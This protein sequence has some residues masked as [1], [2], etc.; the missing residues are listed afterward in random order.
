MRK[1]KQSLFFAGMSI[2]LSMV[3]ALPPGQYLGARERDDLQG[4]KDDRG[5]GKGKGNLCDHPPDPKGKAKGLDD[6]CP[7]GGSSNGVARGDFNNDGFADLAIGV[8]GQV[9]AGRAEAG[10]VIV[11]YGSANRLT[12]TDPSVPASQFWSQDSLGVPDDSEAR[13]GFGSALAAGDFNGDGFSDLAIG[14][15]GDK[16]VRS[17]VGSIGQV[18]VIYGSRVGLTTDI[19]LG[20]PAS[21]R[22]A[23]TDLNIGP[24]Q[25]DFFAAEAEA[26]LPDG[27]SFGAALAWGDFDADGFSDLAVGSP[28]ERIQSLD[29]G[30][31][32][33]GAGAVG[34][35]FG[36]RTGLTVARSFVFTQNSPGVPGDA[37]GVD[38]FGFALAGGDFNGDGASDLAI[39][40]PLKRFRDIRAAGEVVVLFGGDDRFGLGAEGSLVF[41]EPLLA[42]QAPGGF[43]VP[44]TGTGFRFGFALAAGDFNGDGLDDLAMSAPNRTVGTQ[45]QAGAVWVKHG[46]LAPESTP[47]FW[48]Q[49][50]VFPGA[51]I[52]NERDGDGSPPEADDFFGSALAAG[53][54]NG[55]GRDDLAIG[56]PFED[57]L[58]QRTPTTFEQV[59]D[60]GAV[61]VIYGSADGLSI[62]GRRPQ[63]WT[64]QSINIE[65]DA[66]SGD[67]FGTSLTAWNFGGDDDVT[68]PTADLAIGVPFENVGAVRDAGAV[69][70]I[71]GS[72]RFS[73]LTFFDD[74]V[75]TQDDPGI[76]EESEGSE[77][78]DRFGN[79]V[80]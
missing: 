73:G 69:N 22:F 28:E 62:T 48:E 38:R 18:Y 57:V 19:N 35:I 24:G 77:T 6:R 23:I 55:D 63:F 32:P 74:Q 46:P 15:P 53:D 67:R 45:R 31:L 76:P 29:F 72:V 11:I 50:R 7:E 12:A 20:V 47:Q 65:E 56:V 49:S 26:E 27:R 58:V 3:L 68:R 33:F 70:V 79:A 10:A 36:S 8:P 37:V 51:G 40:I 44:L 54:F 39:G 1:A 59:V 78:D 14:A 9:V 21:Q 25:L 17:G 30:G 13:D 66:E 16:A 42:A 34:I 4:G 64:Q 60:A 75:W 41:T 61:N 52:I 71:Y 80:Y 2:I 5:L 43:G